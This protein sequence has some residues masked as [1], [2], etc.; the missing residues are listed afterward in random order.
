MIESSLQGGVR[1]R[2]P[3]SPPPAPQTSN[4]YGEIRKC[5]ACGAH[6]KAGIAICQ[7][8]GHEF[9]GVRAVSS[10]ERL[11]EM[12]EQASQRDNAQSTVHKMF[13]PSF[14]VA[15]VIK[16]FPIPNTVEDLLE[17]CLICEARGKKDRSFPLEYAYYEK[18]CESVNKAK[19]FFGNDARFQPLF[20][21][22][23]EKS[24]KMS[25]DKKKLLIIGGIIICAILFPFLMV[26]IL[27]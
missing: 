1:E 3:Q 4:K 14:E 15:T 5:P 2:K 26:A 22:F 25:D 10:A 19:I 13:T 11:S 16:N 21:R 20:K 17:F 6:V 8:C 18:Y 27:G 24:G 9:V 7:E 23:D 12:V